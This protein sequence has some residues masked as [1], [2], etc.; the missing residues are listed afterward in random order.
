MEICTDFYI[1]EKTEEQTFTCKRERKENLYKGA[2]KIIL[3]KSKN[4][5]AI[6][7]WCLLSLSEIWFNQ[8]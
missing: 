7:Q 2:K 1:I 3:N 6:I 8:D 4:M 5:K